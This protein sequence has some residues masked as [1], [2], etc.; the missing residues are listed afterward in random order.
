MNKFGVVLLTVFVLFCVALS[1][2]AAIYGSF[3]MLFMIVIVGLFLGPSG[4]IKLIKSRRS[5][6]WPVVDGKILE[7]KIIHR[8]TKRRYEGSYVYVPIVKYL[9][10]VNEEPFENDTV[11]YGGA[12][13]NIV[14]YAQ[15]V[16]DKY[17]SGSQVKVYYNPKNPEDAVLEGGQVTVA[18]KFM[19]GLGVFSLLSIITIVLFEVLKS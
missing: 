3:G 10:E 2:F 6:R 13:S 12:N 9:Y 16:C 19:C 4:F 11:R 8:S 17:P 7:S 15:T 1:I 5:R 18:T 14:S